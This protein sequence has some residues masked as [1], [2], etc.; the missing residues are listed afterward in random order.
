MDHLGSLIPDPGNL[1]ELLSQQGRHISLACSLWQLQHCPLFAE[2]FLQGQH[3]CPPGPGHAQPPSREPRAA[4]ALLCAQTLPQSCPILCS[5]QR[6]LRAWV[7]SMGKEKKQQAVGCGVLF[8]FIQ[9]PL[10]RSLYKSAH[11][12]AEGNAGAAW[13]LYIF[14]GTPRKKRGR[15]K[16]RARQQPQQT[17]H[18]Q[19]FKKQGVKP[20]VTPFPG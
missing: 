5:S 20:L 12:N 4:L 17:H 19:N 15:R 6:L 11:E 2:S 8:H 14:T 18:H 10:K 16:S 3:V 13:P 7:C 9:V 1:Q